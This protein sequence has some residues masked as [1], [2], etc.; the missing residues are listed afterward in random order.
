MLLAFLHTPASA[1]AP[2]LANR[3]IVKY[4]TPG[5]GAVQ[6][7]PDA[8]QLARLEA[9]IEQPE[10]EVPTAAEMLQHSTEMASVQPEISRESQWQSK[11]PKRKFISANTREYEFA[12]YMSA[13]VSKVERVGNLNYP[14]ELRARK[15]HGD[16]VMTVGIRRNGTIESIDVR[17]SSGIEEIDRAAVRIVRLAAPY[18]PLPDNIADRVDILHITRTWRFESAFAVS[19]R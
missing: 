11:L 3:L 2:D 9:R 10:Q 12:S 14:A 16:L 1:G 19:Q 13:W 6:A 18:S 4:L 5:A 17:R 8:D 7:E 15:L